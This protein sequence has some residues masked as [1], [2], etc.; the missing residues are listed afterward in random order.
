YELS[1]RERRRLTDAAWQRG[2]STSCTLYRINRITPLYS[3]LP[4]TCYLLGERLVEE[5][6]SFWQR[7]GAAFEFQAEVERFA[8][9]LLQRRCVGSEADAYLEEVLRFELALNSLHFLPRRQIKEQLEAALS[10][11]HTGP[12][13]LHPLVRV[14]VFC[15]DPLP[16]LGA[17]A[18]KRMP[19]DDLV[20]G[21]FFV[22]VDGGQDDFALRLVSPEIGRLLLH[23]ANGREPRPDDGPLVGALV[24]SGL[25]SSMATL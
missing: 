2:M 11:N 10:E 15:H 4:L 12:V 3:L 7:G 21:E 6:R 17:L 25:L 13:Q 16:L 5:A 23:I 24:A 1:G 8:D 22:L 20:S 9:C 18:E 14:L 19:P